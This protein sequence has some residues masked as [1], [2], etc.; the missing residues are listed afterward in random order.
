MPVDEVDIPADR[1]F[2]KLQ[3]LTPLESA[4][5]SADGIGEIIR[6]FKHHPPNS[7]GLKERQFRQQSR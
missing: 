7:L 1:L 4:G 3:Y 5:Q 2:Q 6:Q